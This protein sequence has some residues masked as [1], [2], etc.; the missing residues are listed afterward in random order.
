MIYPVT[1]GFHWGPA[2]FSWYIEGCM[3][4]KGHRTASIDGLGIHHVEQFIQQGVHP[5]TNNQT[6]PDYVEMVV[7]GESSDL[8]SPLEVSQQLHQH[9]DKALGILNG[10]G[11]IENEELS[12]TVEDIWSMSF[13]GKYYAHKISGTSYVALYRKTK[14]EDDQKKAVEELELALDFWQKYTEN[15][16]KQYINPMWMKRV[17]MADWVKFTKYAR[18]DIEMAKQKVE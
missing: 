14:N 12:N 2:D 9:A 5:G 1:P 3:S 13:L 17:G 7:K 18:Q 8:T 6:I 16:M 4:R 10:L 11:P 15:A